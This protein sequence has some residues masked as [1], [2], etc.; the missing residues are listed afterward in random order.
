[1]RRVL[2]AITLVG[3]AALATACTP[4][5]GDD[6]SRGDI[7]AALRNTGMTVCGTNE[8]PVDLDGVES[9]VELDLAVGSCESGRTGQ[10]VIATH[11]SESERDRVDNAVL[12]V[13]RPRFA[14]ALWKLGSTTVVLTG[15]PDDDVVERVQD[16][17]EALG[18]A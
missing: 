3:V 8:D 10:I 4:D 18:A 1:V 16:A 5:D 9:A 12:A 15:V 7:E 2:V 13:P 6:R 11:P 14:D 17:M